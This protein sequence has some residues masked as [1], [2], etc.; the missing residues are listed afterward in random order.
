M[1]KHPAYNASVHA[2]GGIG[3]GVLITYPFVGQHP[4]RVGVAFIIVAII[5]HIYTFFA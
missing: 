5:G 4:V 1:K 2:I 3:L